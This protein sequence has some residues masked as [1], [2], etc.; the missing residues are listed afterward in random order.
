MPTKMID[1]KQGRV[2]VMEFG[3]GEPILYF[4]GTGITGE[5]M[6]RLERPVANSGFQLIVPNRPAY[7]NTPL[8][9]HRS[10]VAC[11]SKVHALP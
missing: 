2:E 10:A 4:H 3:A 5:A 11:Q 8:V 7:G 9:G 6:A 1:T